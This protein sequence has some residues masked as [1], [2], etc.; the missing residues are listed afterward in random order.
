MIEIVEF[1]SIGFVS[2]QDEPGIVVNYRARSKLFRMQVDYEG[3]S[4]IW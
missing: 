1:K 4:G 2:F 3:I